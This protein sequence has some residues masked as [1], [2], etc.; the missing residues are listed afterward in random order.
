M[1][2][3]IF[4]IPLSCILFFGLSLLL[5]VNS[6]EAAQRQLP[7]RVRVILSSLSPLLEEGKYDMAISRITTSQKKKQGRI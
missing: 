7:P 2:K 5:L 3:T 1:K 6:L 4:F